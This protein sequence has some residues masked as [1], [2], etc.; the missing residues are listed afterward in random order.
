MLELPTLRRTFSS[1]IVSPKGM[2]SVIML[3][4]YPGAA[5]ISIN[6]LI[7]PFF[8]ADTPALDSSWQTISEG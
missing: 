3:R 4:L 6:V 8:S 5:P 1:K 7:A 2:R